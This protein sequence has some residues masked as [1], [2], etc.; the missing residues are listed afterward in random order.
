MIDEDLGNRSTIDID[1]FPY[2]RDMPLMEEFIKALGGF[3]STDLSALSGIETLN[4]NALR[5][6]GKSVAVNKV[7]S[8]R[9]QL[10]LL[11]RQKTTGVITR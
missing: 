1:G 6:I 2:Y 8:G 9:I 3:Q 10:F 11:L 4:A 7:Y 5:A